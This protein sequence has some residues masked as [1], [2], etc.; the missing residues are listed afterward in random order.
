MR[1]AQLFN[2]E[3]LGSYDYSEAFK[4]AS[5][6]LIKGGWEVWLQVEWAKHLD[7]KAGMSIFN[8]QREENYPN[9]REK[10]DFL[11]WYTYRDASKLN[12]DVTYVELKCTN[13]FNKTI[14]DAQTDAL[15]RFASDIG[16]VADKT[17]PAL[18]ILVYYGDIGAAQGYFSN[19]P[20]SEIH[21][22]E[23]VQKGP[24]GT[25]V[26]RGNLAAPKIKNQTN[27][28]ILGYEP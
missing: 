17:D 21:V 7:A 1:F 26:S 23:Y 9:S 24:K 6:S 8:I 12:H 22:L 4:L 18:C 3:H 25:M 16:K 13:M 14:A 2:E 10:C 20:L 19:R 28:F 11:I 5:Q 27:M 15:N